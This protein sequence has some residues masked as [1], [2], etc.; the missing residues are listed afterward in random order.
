MRH[1]ELTMQSFRFSTQPTSLLTIAVPCLVLPCAIASASIHKGMEIDNKQRI[2]G[3]RHAFYLQQMSR[4]QPH[5]DTARAMYSRERFG[6]FTLKGKIS[7]E[8]GKST[9]RYS[10]FGIDGS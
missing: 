3:V 9:S 5:V 1:A 10:F 2:F 6:N 4:W 7:L 8:P